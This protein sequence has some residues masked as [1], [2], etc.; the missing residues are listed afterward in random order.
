LCVCVCGWGGGVEAK[1]GCLSA[2][3]FHGMWCRDPAPL[4]P[5][6]VPS[7]PLGSSPPL[8]SRPN[9]AA[10]TLFPSLSSPAGRAGHARSAGGTG[11]GRHSP[12]PGQGGGGGCCGGPGGQQGCCR[13]RGGPDALPAV[14]GAGAGGRRAA[15]G[16][17]GRSLQEAAGRGEGGSHGCWS[18]RR[19]RRWEE[20]AG[21]AALRHARWEDLLPIPTGI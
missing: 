17:R 6:P 9:N 18:C 11:S 13:G 3:A 5:H 8:G 7:R 16:G 19:R 10:F 21:W 12:A 2:S 15:A 4:A 1:R 14:V 20:A